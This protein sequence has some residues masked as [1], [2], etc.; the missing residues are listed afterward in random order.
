[1]PNVVPQLGPG[2]RRGG[3][4]TRS[5]FFGFFMFSREGGSPGLQALPLGTLDPRVRE[6]A[7]GFAGER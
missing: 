5:R 4:T 7:G 2:L 6:G 1:M 3:V